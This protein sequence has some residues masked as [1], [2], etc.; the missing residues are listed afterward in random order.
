MAWTTVSIRTRSSPYLNSS[1]N[2]YNR[3]GLSS[4]L[5]RRLLPLHNTQNG[6]EIYYYLKQ[7]QK[8]ESSHPIWFDKVHVH[9]GTQHHAQLAELKRIA[10][11][12]LYA[13]QNLTGRNPNWKDPFLT[14]ELEVVTFTKWTANSRVGFWTIPRTPNAKKRRAAVKHW[15]RRICDTRACTVESYLDL[16]PTEAPIYCTKINYFKKNG[17]H[18]PHF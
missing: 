12:E 16:S 5:K 15:E 6:P 3:V 11:M 14:H 2:Q 8:L 13:P 4:C 10:S 17:Y 9:N 1:G 7:Q 18:D